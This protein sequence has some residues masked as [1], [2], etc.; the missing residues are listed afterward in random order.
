MGFYFKAINGWQRNSRAHVDAAIAVGFSWER[1]ALLFI[2][3]AIFSTYR[4][5]ML[6]GLGLLALLESALV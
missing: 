2:P 4:Q 3:L 6:G 5:W 1:L